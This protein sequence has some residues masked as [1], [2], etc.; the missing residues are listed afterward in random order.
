[1]GKKD[2]KAGPRPAKQAAKTAQPK[3]WR[4]FLLIALAATAI[5]LSPVAGNDFINFDDPQYVTTNPIVQKLNGENI[6]A[7]F[8]EQ[9]V[10]NYQPVVMLSYAIQYKLFS[11][12]AS[13]YHFFSLLL[14]L[15]NTALVFA[16]VYR[17]FRNNHAALITALLFGMHPLHVESVAWVSAQKDLIYSFFFFGA[18]YFYLRQKE[19][20]SNK[21]LVYSL[22]CFILSVLS[23]AQ[24]V[25]LPVVLLLFDYLQQKQI[26]FKDIRQKIPHF[27]IALAF[28][29]LAIAVQRK[30]GAVQDFGYFSIGER[31][32]FAAYGFVNYLWQAVLPVHLSVFYPYPE[33]NDRINS[34]WVYIAPVI[35]L[36]LAVMVFLLR[37][38]APVVVFGSLFF[39]VTIALVLQLIPVGDAIHADRYTY[40]SLTG[41]FIIAGYYFGRSMERKDLRQ[42]LSIAALVVLGLFAFLSFGRSRQWKDSI[43]IYSASL[44]HHP[45]P[46]M[47]SNRGAAY[48]EAGNIQEALKDFEEAVRIRPRFPNAAKNLGLTYEKLGNAQKA[49][50]A[51]TTAIQHYPNDAG[52][53][54]LRANCYK[55]AQRYEEAV[56]DYS[57]VI[58]K[59]PGAADAWFGRAEA[60]GRWGKLQ[61]AVNDF[62]KVIELQPGYDAAYN[63][64]GIAFSMAG[65]FQAALNDFN[66]A[67][68]LNPKFWNAYYNRSNAY[69]AMGDK[70]RALQDAM[71]AKQNGYPVGD[72]YITALQQ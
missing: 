67:I 8:T 68:Q 32:L 62:S 54:L 24:A 60:Y 12:N 16:I 6:K 30:A 37:R 36:A 70:Q 39:C 59:N 21:L 5:A 53:Y 29:L 49:A 3:Q 63:N 55:G 46:I 25:V 71:M 1:M 17:L 38:R 27:V 44:E 45:A 42:R 52:T 22:L 14:H 69:K 43:S 56:K 18:I 58:G 51:Y 31:I 20:G 10:G 9:F 66:K 28:G 23:K 65:N 57:Y 33:T 40:I 50:E 4:N 13:G 41:L 64:R 7:F 11:L 15:L 72:E 48:Y 19:E 61:E 26:T 34:N 47:Y 2:K 35:I